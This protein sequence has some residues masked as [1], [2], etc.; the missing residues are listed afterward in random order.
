MSG[1][2]FYFQVPRY[3][4]QFGIAVM[5]LTRRRFAP[6]CSQKAITSQC[7]SSTVHDHSSPQAKNFEKWP[8]LLMKGIFVIRIGWKL[9]K[10]KNFEK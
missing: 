7:Q 6:P 1:K 5:E 4:F 2:K 10:A 8:I 9:T 3:F